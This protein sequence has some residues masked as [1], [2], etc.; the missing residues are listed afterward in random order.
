MHCEVDM[1]LTDF[2]FPPVA[3]WR[4]RVQV[5]RRSSFYTNKSL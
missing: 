1:M 4:K 5:P 3:Y 2:F